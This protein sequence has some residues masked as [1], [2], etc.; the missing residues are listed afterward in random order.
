MNK[1]Q[2]QDHLFKQYTYIRFSDEQ[3]K[4][5]ICF[6]F[7]ESCEKVVIQTEIKKGEFGCEYCSS[8]NITLHE[9]EE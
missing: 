5:V 4:E 7:C 9:V 2:L 1:Q 8:Q 6:D 3:S